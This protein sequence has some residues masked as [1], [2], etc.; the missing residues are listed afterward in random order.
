M[1]RL[2]YSWTIKFPKVLPNYTLT[3]VAT[4]AK[5]A[6]AKA[7]LTRKYHTMFDGVR[8]EPTEKEKKM[9]IKRLIASGNFVVENQKPL[10]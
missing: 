3:A 4:S 10:H 7:I 8:Y 9:L 2:T 1:K 5:E 6:I